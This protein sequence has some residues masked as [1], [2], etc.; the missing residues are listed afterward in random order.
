[1]Y[2]TIIASVIVATSATAHEMTPTYPEMRISFLEGVYQT[3]LTLFNRRE[4]IEFYQVEVFTESFES[5]PF[6]TPYRILASPH[7][8]RI[9]FDVYIR[10]SDLDQAHYICTRSKV[11]RADTSRQAVTSRICSKIRKD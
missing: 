6:A 8:Q 4:E 1:M 11:A 3:S 5:V 10:E 2:R 7:L 9:Q